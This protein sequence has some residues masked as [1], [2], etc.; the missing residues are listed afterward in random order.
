MRCVLHCI[1]EPVQ[2]GL[3]LLEVLEVMRFVLHG[4]LGGMRC[5]LHCMLEPVQGGLCLL[6]VLEVMEC[7][8]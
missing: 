3:C 1:L 2:G 6:E 7:R 8:R 5:V 4:V